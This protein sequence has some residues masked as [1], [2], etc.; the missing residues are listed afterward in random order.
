MHKQ[1]G[2]PAKDSS[3]MWRCDLFYQGIHGAS[4]VVNTIPMLLKPHFVH[5]N[6]I[7]HT[8]VSFLNEVT[9]TKSVDDNADN[10]AK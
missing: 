8:S 9:G 7:M 1:Y 10:E 4:Y 2:C 5:V 6:T 3:A